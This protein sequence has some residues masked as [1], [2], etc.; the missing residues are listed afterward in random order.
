MPTTRATTVSSVAVIAQR[1]D[2]GE[3]VAEHDPAAVRRGEQQPAGEAALEV[4]GDPEAGEDAAERR[5]L[6]QHEDELERRVAVREVEPR[7]RSA[8]CESPPA[9]AVKKKSGN[10]IDGSSSAG[11]VTT[12]FIVRHATPDGDRPEPHVRSIRRPSAH[13][14][15][16]ESRRRDHDG[17]AEAERE[18]LPSQPLMIRLRTHSIRYETGLMVA[19]KRNQST[20]IRLRGVFIEE[21]K[22]KT[23]RT[24]KSPWIASPEPVRSARNDAE[25]AEADRHDGREERAARGSRAAPG[26][27][28]DADE[29]ADGDVE[30]RL[31]QAEHDDPGERSGEQ[32]GAAHRVSE[33]RFRKPSGCRARDRCPRSWS[34]T[35]RPG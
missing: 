16:D 33:S 17:D 4:A 27:E 24:G 32:R 18:R 7:A 35:A 6:Q 22:R 11:V 14:A 34:R 31:H 30:D 12:F 20:A 10:R 1:S 26:R 3:R 28:V 15:R 5:R 8:T 9:N 29:Q 23:K 19:T 13:D 2:R 21:R 25:R